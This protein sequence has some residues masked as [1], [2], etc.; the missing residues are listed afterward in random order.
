MSFRFQLML[1]SEQDKQST[2]HLP[3]QLR[4]QFLKIRRF[5]KA[6]A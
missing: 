6:N 3:Q 5:G 4:A 1:S 2:Y